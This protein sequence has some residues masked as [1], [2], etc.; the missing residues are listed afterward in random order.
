MIRYVDTARTISLPAGSLFVA[1]QT[2]TAPRLVRARRPS[3]RWA[4]VSGVA[5]A[6]GP[7]GSEGSAAS[8]GA[9]AS[10]PGGVRAPVEES[11]PDG[12]TADS[13]KNW[14]SAKQ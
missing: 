14:T 1:G 9:A 2:K 7:G 8:G 5:G 4:G 12:E 6:G 13:P 10:G 11:A 3:P